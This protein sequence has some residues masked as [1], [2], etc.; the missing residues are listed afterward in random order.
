MA[1]IS[2]EGISLDGDEDDGLSF[3]VDGDAEAKHDLQLCLVGRFLTDRP[4][5]VLIM[6]ARM[7]GI[8]RPVKGVTIKE[9]SP[10]L[11]L[12]LFFHVRDMEA[13]LRGGGGPWSFDSHL[14]ILGR[15][16][17]GTLIQELSLFHV[18][19]WVQVHNLPVG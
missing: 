18:E 5:R 6:K 13:V 2:L 14:L 11:F 1:D 17:I 7:A 3:Q 19:F 12:F 9:A 15:M 10:G 8:W 16:Q 4:I